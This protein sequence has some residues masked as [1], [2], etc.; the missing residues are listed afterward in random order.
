MRVESSPGNTKIDTVSNAVS[1]VDSGQWTVDS[2]QWTVDTI[3]GISWNVSLTSGLQ[4]S[5]RGRPPLLPTAYSPGVLM[6]STLSTLSTLCPCF[7]L[8][9]RHHG[10]RGEA[11]LPLLVPAP[12]AAAVAPRAGTSSGQCEVVQWSVGGQ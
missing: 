6:V 12:G 10:H 9:L 8:L 2:G 1:S 5:D 7:P 11:G 4:W 3:R